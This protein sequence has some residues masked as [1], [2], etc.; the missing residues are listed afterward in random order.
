MLD[1]PAASRMM[2]FCS[3]GFGKESCICSGEAAG[4]LCRHRPAPEG[5]H[6]RL[7]KKLN[8]IRLS[9]RQG[10]TG[11]VLEFTAET[12]SCYDRNCR[13]ARVLQAKNMVWRTLSFSLI[14]AYK[15]REKQGQ[16]KG[17]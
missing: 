5:Y 15:N 14:I 11:T 12:I 8:G 2:Q 16:G 9:L 13:R 10:Y 17:I 7:D 6:C 4:C 1:L 3:Y